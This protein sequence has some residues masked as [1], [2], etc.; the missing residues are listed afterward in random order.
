MWLFDW[1]SDWLFDGDFTSGI[2]ASASSKGCINDD[3]MQTSLSASIR[4]ISAMDA[5]VSNPMGWPDTSC[6]FETNP[7]NGLPMTD[8]IG[9]VDVI[10]NSY[11]CDNSALSGHDDSFGGHLGGGLSD[12]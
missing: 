6:S 3:F 10:G 2:D 12:W 1:V 11:G 9:S 4:N 8:G 7:A 5:D